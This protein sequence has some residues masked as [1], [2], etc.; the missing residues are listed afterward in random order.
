MKQINSRQDLKYFLGADKKALKRKT[1][2]PKFAADEIWKFQI[3]LRKCEFFL[4][5]SC[6]KLAAANC[7]IMS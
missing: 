7:I 1:N 6:I 3:R 4:N 2:K 5:V